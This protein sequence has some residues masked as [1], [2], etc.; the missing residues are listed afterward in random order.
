MHGLTLSL[1][2]RVSLTLAR[3]GDEWRYAEW[4]RS[5]DGSLLPPPPPAACAKRFATPEQAASYFRAILEPQGRAIEELEQE[6][7]AMTADVGTGT[8]R[9]QSPDAR[10]QQAKRKA[11]TE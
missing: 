2:E 5:G 3:E 10:W 6:L 8:R 4:T 11:E 9:G 1:S 7:A